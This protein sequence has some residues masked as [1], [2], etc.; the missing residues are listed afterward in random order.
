M[1]SCQSSVSF[2]KVIFSSTVSYHIG[3]N[4]R[5]ELKVMIL[6]MM[7]FGRL[8]DLKTLTVEARVE[9]QGIPFFLQS[10]HF[11]VFKVFSW[12][13]FIAKKRRFF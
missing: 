6:R 9:R 5:D 12:E 7:N 8:Q 11:D 2:V 1:V 4:D 3:I 13:Q 10:L